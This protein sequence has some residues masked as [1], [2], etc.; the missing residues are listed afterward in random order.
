[1]TQPGDPAARAGRRIA[2]WVGA[3]TRDVASGLARGVAGGIRWPDHELRRV[4][5]RTL[6]T[7]VFAQSLGGVGITIG[8]AVAAI[9]AEQ[10]SGSAGLAG[11]AQTMQVLGSA[12]ASFLLAHLMGRRGR[13]PGLVLGYLLGAAGAALCVVSG[14][15]ESFALLL[16]GATLLGATTAANNQSR[17]TATDLAPPDRRARSLSL[18]VWATTF[19]AVAG[20]NLTGVAGRAAREMGLPGLVG[21]FLFGLVGILAAGVVVAVFLPGSAR[22][23]ASVPA[24][25][26][27]WPPSRSRTR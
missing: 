21:P 17:Y 24:S 20:P 12:V 8:I 18:V 22:S 26:P 23:S 27:A 11:L 13:R 4:Q 9:L 25:A 6:G 5:R 1:M 16:V 10:L 2:G 15:V 7:L 19:G 14:M 3:G